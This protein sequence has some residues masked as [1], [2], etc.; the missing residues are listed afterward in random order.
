[1]KQ[2]VLLEV[3]V[4]KKDFCLE[5]FL[6]ESK[7]F[8]LNLVFHWILTMKSFIVDFLIKIIIDNDEISYLLFYV[9]LVF[10]YGF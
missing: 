4:D 2:K 7:K 3:M 6:S 5:L 1:M 9:L 8:Y 10:V